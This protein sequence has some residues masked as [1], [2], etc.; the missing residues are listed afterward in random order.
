M[1]P[2][3][4]RAVTAAAEI[5]AAA[6]DMVEE[7]SER[8]VEPEFEPSCTY[9][10][11]LTDLARQNCARTRHK[12]P[13][14]TRLEWS[15]QPKARSV[16]V[17]LL[18]YTNSKYCTSEFKPQATF[19]IQA[20]PGPER[21][22]PNSGNPRSIPGKIRKQFTHAKHSPSLLPSLGVSQRPTHLDRLNHYLPRL[23]RV[24]KHKRPSGNAGKRE[25]PFRQERFPQEPCKNNEND[26][27]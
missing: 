7:S 22:L 5:A 3:I 10:V 9:Q 20:N 13:L 25:A 16:G 11:R 26:A 27:E 8:R 24:D 1:A 6:P 14:S 18:L 2:G 15:L 19:Q 21:S 23:E 12:L 17:E 4:A